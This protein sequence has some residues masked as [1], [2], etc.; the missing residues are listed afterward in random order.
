[1][2]ADI[3]SVFAWLNLIIGLLVAFFFF[4]ISRE[5]FFTDSGSLIV[6]FSILLGALLQFAVLG[7]LGE[8]VRRLAS[9]DETLKVQR[10]VARRNDEGPSLTF[11]EKA[12]VL[13][14]RDLK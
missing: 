7:G 6:A 5:S 9:I 2:K 10:A 11:G 13:L 8:I 3:L 1:M 4:N 12:Q 14:G